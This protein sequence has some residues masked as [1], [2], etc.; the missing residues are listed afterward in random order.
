MPDRADDRGG[1]IRFHI[2]ATARLGAVFIRRHGYNDQAFLTP[3]QAPVRSRPERQQTRR[4]GDVYFETL[5]FDI[6]EGLTTDD[7]VLRPIT[8]ADAEMDYAAVM[9]SRDFLQT[10]EQ[11]S[12]PEV[13]FTVAGNLEDM[14]K[15]ERRHA[16][17]H[18][19]TYTIVNPD[20]T[21]CLG[22]VYIMPP[23]ARSFTKSRITPIGSRRW[24]D[25]DAAVYFWVRK[26]RLATGTDRV[27]LDALRTWFAWNW[28]FRRY[29]IVTSEL[30][31]QQVEMIGNTDL[32]LGFEILDSGK[33]GRYLAYE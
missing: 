32:E 16:A 10:W 27:L 28:K 23:D 15:L 7:F 5:D 9:E 25:Y 24:D 29:L 2:N 1:M 33:P 30:F 18:S 8:A 4:S 13:N 12:W 20:G 3:A 21:E 31:T 19:F 26:S 17:R 14:V 6:P 11:T 22:C